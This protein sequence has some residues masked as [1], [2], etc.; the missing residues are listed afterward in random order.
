MIGALGITLFGLFMFTA[1]PPDIAGD[2]TGDEWGRVALKKTTDGEYQGTYSDTFGKEQGVIQLTWSRIERRFNGTWREGKERFGEISVRLVDREIRGAFTTDV[3]SKIN[4]GTPHLVDL[5]WT[6]F[7]ASSAASRVDSGPLSHRVP[8][9]LGATL[10]AGGD[11]ITIDEVRGTADSMKAGN[12]YEI[13]GTYRLAS[14]DKAMLAVYVTGEG[15]DAT[16]RQPSDAPTVERGEGRFSLVL[17]MSYDGKPHVSFYPVD[18]GEG[19]GHVYFG[20]GDS[21]LK[22]GWWKSPPARV[23]VLPPKASGAARRWIYPFRT[24]ISV[25]K[26]ALSDDAKQIVVTDEKSTVQILNGTNGKLVITLPLTTLDEDALLAETKRGP[27]S[28]VKALAFS[29]DGKSIAVGTSVG[30]VKLFNALTGELIS[31]LD[32]E[33]ARLKDNKTPN[34]FKS[35]KRALG[36]V[37]ALAFSP[38]GRVLVTA[39]KAIGE[40]SLVFDAIERELTL[41]VTGPGRL[42]VWDVKTG[43]LKYDLVGHDS[44]LNAIAV[45]PDGHWLASVGSWTDGKHGSG[46]IIWNLQTGDKARAITNSDNGGTWS[47]AFSPD[48][49]LLA[50]GSISFDKDKDHD[51]ATTFLSITRAGSGIV[52]WRKS[53]PRWTTVKGFS[54]DG[55]TVV[56]LCQDHNVALIDSQTGQNQQTIASLAGRTIFDLEIAPRGSKLVVGGKRFDADGGWIEIGDFNDPPADDNA[57]E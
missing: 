31:S 43:A 26:L 10:L 34:K 21:V 51:A 53:I 12:R 9:E 54:P 4:P 35:L 55:K 57:K 39:G 27:P 36:G 30:Q 47:V 19:F 49:K 2:W 38:D 17:H 44:H 48:G 24:S 32:D 41:S 42:K 45:S 40:E 29:P 33:A 56:V 3:R 6:R 7:D 15:K 20:T 46:A 5:A 1:D 37:T 11:Q 18:G 22:R 13:K 28:E 16:D 50:I 8:F 23:R 14:R 52:E 25:S